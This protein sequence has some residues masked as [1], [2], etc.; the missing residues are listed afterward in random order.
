[1]ICES[2]MWRGRLVAAIGRVPGL[3]GL[4]LSI[5]IG[6]QTHAADTELPDLA[7]EQLQWLAD[8]IFRNE[9]NRDVNCL[10]SWNVGEDFPSL[11]IGH[12]I[13]Y[14]A[15]QQERFVESFPALLAYYVA[16]GTSLPAWLAGAPGWHSPWPDRETFQAEQ[17]SERMRELRQFLLDTRDVQAD[18]IVR[19][20][21]EALPTIAASAER[22]AEVTSLFYEVANTAPPFGM[23]ALIDYINFKGEGT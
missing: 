22:P 7:T 23:Y 17:D 18:F 20:M 11:G 21:H 16:R 8:Q 12:F 2:S 19:R 3:I 6:G 9:C 10:T 1:M 14:R 5:L 15:D 13:W 4:L